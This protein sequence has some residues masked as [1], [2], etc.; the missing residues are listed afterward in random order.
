MRKAGLLFVFAVTAS[1]CQLPQG[2]A[3]VSGGFGGPCGSS[4]DF[5][6]NLTNLAI[7][8]ELNIN[9]N[10]NDCTP[11][12][13]WT[14]ANGHAQSLT[15][16][17]NSAPTVSSSLQANGVLSWSSSGTAAN[18]GFGWQLERAPA[19][20]VTATIGA[21]AS[22][23]N[24]PCGSSGTAYRNLRNASVSLG[25]AVTGGSSS[26]SITLS[27]TDASGHA[28]TLTSNETVS[29]GAST[30]LPAGEEITWTS[31]GTGVV[32]FYQSQIERVD[33]SKLW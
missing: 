11:T 25:L 6:T 19:Q 14:D 1:L 24:P 26:C 8:F 29:P 2:F 3:S 16:A 28:Q 27:W 17:A 32:E 10:F 18:A 15:V 20:S 13:S 31:T 22:P 7:H 12:I 33:P 21:F 9:N 30:T 4:G 5:Y 23:D